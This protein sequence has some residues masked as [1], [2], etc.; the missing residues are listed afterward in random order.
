[1]GFTIPKD[2][3]EAKRAGSLAQIVR[4]SFYP[5]TR[6][7][8]QM[9]AGLGITKIQFIHTLAIYQSGKENNNMSHILRSV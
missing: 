5:S 2:Y 3:F 8:L 7:E 4:L 9:F 1:M 6:K